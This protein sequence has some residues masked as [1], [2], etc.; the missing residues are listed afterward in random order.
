MIFTNYFASEADISQRNRSGIKLCQ[1]TASVKNDTTSQRFFTRI[2]LEFPK[3]PHSSKT[4]KKIFTK[5]CLLK[6]IV[7]NCFQLFVT[8]T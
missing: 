4:S 8:K 7:S 3:Q 2:M 5:N 1:V 6:N